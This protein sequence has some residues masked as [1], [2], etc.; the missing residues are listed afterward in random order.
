VEA[1]VSI[2]TAVRY[3]DRDTAR[4]LRGAADK[5]DEYVSRLVSG[6][7]YDQKGFSVWAVLNECIKTVTEAA[8]LPSQDTTRHT[9]H[10]EDV[11]REFTTVFHELHE[12]SSVVN[13]RSPMVADEYPNGSPAAPRS[14]GPMPSRMTMVDDLAPKGAPG[15]R[16]GSAGQ[17]GVV[18]KTTS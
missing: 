18:S 4:K 9:A 6:D 2:R 11:P 16:E 15:P 3:C 14:P 7:R 12:M 10:D 8:R 13:A 17:F 5:L 1:Q